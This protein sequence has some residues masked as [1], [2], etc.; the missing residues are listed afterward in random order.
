MS[1]SYN[2]EL[3]IV[4]IQHLKEVIMPDFTLLE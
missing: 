4:D 1:L 3:L 2:G